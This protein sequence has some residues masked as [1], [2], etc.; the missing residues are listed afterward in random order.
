MF[1]CE[2]RVLGLGI[3]NK[4]N[5]NS[6]QPQNLKKSLFSENSPADHQPE[7]CQNKNKKIQVSTV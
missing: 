2:N 1:R 7:N 5:E 6:K 3:K 4:K